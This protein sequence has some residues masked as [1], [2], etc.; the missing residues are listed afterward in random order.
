MNGSAV[1]NYAGRQIEFWL[2][3]AMGLACGAGFMGGREWQQQHVAMRLLAPP[4][5]PAPAP[6]ATWVIERTPDR[7]KLDELAAKFESMVRAAT[8]RVDAI[9]HRSMTDER[10]HAG[11]MDDLVAINNC[12][13]NIETTAAQLRE[14]DVDVA[15]GE[16]QD[17]LPG[18]LP[19]G[20][21]DYQNPPDES[22][23]AGP[24]DARRPA[25][26]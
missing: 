8:E 23:K 4:P 25:G 12:L 14:S 18:C 19:G 26:Q 24:R 15:K 1:A 6:R 13:A 16:P 5:P 9:A 2:V 10:L 21:G 3:V 22:L 17:D 20:V 11:L 7:V